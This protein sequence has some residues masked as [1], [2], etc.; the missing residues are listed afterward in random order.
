MKYEHLYVVIEHEGGKPIPVSLEMLG[1]ARRLMDGYNSKYG[2]SELVVAVVLGNNVRKLCD[3]LV[4]YGADAVIYA[5][6]P[7]LE[8]SRNAVDT[9]VLFQIATNREL[10]LKFAP[11][12]TGFVKPRYMFF[13]AG[14]SSN[15]S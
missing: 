14:L 13:A 5:D 1:E 7:E 8:Y 3:Q 9:P 6:S 15:E 10:V 4:H 11:K 2:A 12:S